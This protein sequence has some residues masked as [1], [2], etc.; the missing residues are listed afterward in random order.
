[1]LSKAMCG[2]NSSN[3]ALFTYGLC[4]YKKGHL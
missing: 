1:V 3:T 2:S 4:E